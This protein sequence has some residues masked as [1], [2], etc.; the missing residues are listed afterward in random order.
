MPRFYRTFKDFI[1]EDRSKRG[2]SQ[3]KFSELVGIKNRKTISHWENGKTRPDD[4][5]AVVLKLGYSEDDIVI[6]V[7]D[8]KREFISS[9]KE[10]LRGKFDQL[11]ILKIIGR[12]SFLNWKQ[13][14]THNLLSCKCEDGSKQRSLTKIVGFFNKN[15]PHVNFDEDRLELWIG[16]RNGIFQSF[17]CDTNIEGHSICLHLK[18]KI[19]QE[20]INGE[21]GETAIELEDFAAEGEPYSFYI[22]S[23]NSNGNEMSYLVLKNIVNHLHERFGYPPDKVGGV[24]GKIDGVQ[25]CERFGLK[26]QYVT[27]AENEEEGFTYYGRQVRSVTYDAPLDALSVYKEIQ[28]G[29]K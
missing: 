21:R 20:I 4:I 8:P 12:A 27:L 17:E 14:K 2:V 23:L 11:K 7:Y 28:S 10:V 24:C 5:K 9:L 3:E 6:G 29:I 13:F 16:S 1:I 25:L 26:E 18:P 19:F 15:R 22:F